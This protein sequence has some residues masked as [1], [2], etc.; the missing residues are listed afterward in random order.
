ME[1]LKSFRQGFKTTNEK[2][3][4][5][6][7]LWLVNFIFSILMI[8]P[9]YFLLQKEFSR[10][11]IQ[12]RI[13]QGFD[14]F[15]F[16][17][18]AYKYKDF[19]PPF[20]GWILVP[21]IFFLLLFIFLNGGILGRVVAQGE[22]VNFE[23]FLADC[24]KYLFRFFRVF[25]ISLVGYFVVFGLIFRAISALFKLW[26]KNASTEWPLILSANLKFLIIIL[27]FSIARMF[28]DYVRV[29]LV[30]EESKKTIRATILNFSFIGKRF[31]KAW[32]LY[33]L[34]ALITIILGI[35]YL[36][37]SQHFPQIGILLIVFFFL[38]QIYILSKMWT[39]VLFF[40]TEY[41]FFKS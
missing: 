13:A 36:V 37:I 29:R 2:W 27:L 40:S 26:T 5:V 22:K 41:H 10:S 28:F 19:Y 9:V 30:V 25:L 21:G 11:L 24:G 3:K 33:L 18:I 20:L 31:F 38:Q 1:V 6:V 15:W 34:V 7:Y 4:L 32:F 35:I 16:G 23:N 39:R 12:N 17:D 14:L 8:T